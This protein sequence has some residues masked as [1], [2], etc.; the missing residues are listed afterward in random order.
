MKY[1]YFYGP[2]LA[3]SGLAYG[4]LFK[5]LYIPSSRD[6]LLLRHRESSSGPV[7]DLLLSTDTLEFIHQGAIYQRVEKVQAISKWKLAQQN[8]RVCP[9]SV[10]RDDG[11]NCS[12]CEKCI[13]TMLVLYALGEMESFV[14]FVKPMKAN[15]EILWWARKFNPARGY[16]GEIFQLARAHKPAM[17]P[18][19]WLA[20]ILGYIRFGLLKIIPKFIII[21][22]QSYGYFINPYEAEYAFDDPRIIQA[23]RSKFS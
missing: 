2:I 3:G 5:R 12:R 9:H 11:L 4:G 17:I 18:W 21:R 8:L 23:L 13:R 10:F 14:T 20:A 7:T 16:V 22:L 6:Y 19:L 15:W 1:R